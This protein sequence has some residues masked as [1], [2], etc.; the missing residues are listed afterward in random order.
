MPTVLREGP[1]AFVFFATDQVEPRHIHVKRDR[2]AAKFWLEPVSL[3]RNDGFAEHELHEIER[4]VLQH[5][6]TF[7]RAWDDFFGS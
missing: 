3:A 7:V 5:Q 4:R 6:A 2:Q 1:Y